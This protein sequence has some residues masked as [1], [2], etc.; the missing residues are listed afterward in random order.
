VIWGR[1]GWGLAPAPVAYILNHMTDTYIYGAR[2]SNSPRSHLHNHTTIPSIVA[3]AGFQMLARGYM[4]DRMRPQQ[5]A[6]EFDTVEF[7][8]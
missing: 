6:R 2:V 3:R 1:P 4:C 5:R 7:L 8:C